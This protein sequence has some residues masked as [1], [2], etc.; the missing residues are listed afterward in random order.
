M[1]VFS[2]KEAEIKVGQYPFYTGTKPKL[3]NT[4]TLWRV[5]K[6]PVWCVPVSVREAAFLFLRPNS[7]IKAQAEW[8]Q[9]ADDI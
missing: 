5:P 7:V 2:L 9:F 6:S 3:V 4:Y 8:V 1:V